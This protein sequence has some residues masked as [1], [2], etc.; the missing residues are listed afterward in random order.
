MDLFTVYDGLADNVFFVYLSNTACSGDHNNEEN[1]VTKR[2]WSSKESVLPLLKANMSE[3]TC[4]A[5]VTLSWQVQTK[6]RHGKRM[7]TK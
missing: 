3:E 4:K 1:L 7:H 6:T 5:S 2:K